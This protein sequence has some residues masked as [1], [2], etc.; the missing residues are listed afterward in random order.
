MAN[1]EKAKE[2][3]EN[4][5]IELYQE[6]QEEAARLRDQDILQKRIRKRLEL[7]DAYH[8]QIENKKLLLKKAKEEE[9]V[10]REKLT[11]KFAEDE[12]L[13]QMT[14]QKRRLKKLEHKQAIEALIDER[15]KR[16]HQ[17]E[18]EHKKELERQQE[19]DKYRQLV[20]E[21]ERQRL[22]RE[23][24]GKLVGFLPK[25]RQFLAR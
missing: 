20:I 15:R 19:L 3:L 17:D 23:H 12:R 10:F 9:D 1:K 21:Q 7:L 22:L 14:Q 16:L 4:L 6:E 13:E 2:E 18:V 25:V 11:Q 5:R 24:A 8:Q